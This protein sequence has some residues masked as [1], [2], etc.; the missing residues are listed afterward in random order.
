M[1][2]GDVDLT[3]I[4]HG[5]FF[6]DVSRTRVNFPPDGNRSAGDVSQRWNARLRDVATLPLILIALDRLARD[7]PPGMRPVS[8]EGSWVRTCTGATVSR[9]AAKSSRPS[10]SNRRRPAG[11]SYLLARRSIRFPA[12]LTPRSMA[13]SSRG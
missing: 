12:P 11:G 3:L 2:G 8:L 4:L 10:A 13:M 5:D 1:V 6:P 9:F 7:D